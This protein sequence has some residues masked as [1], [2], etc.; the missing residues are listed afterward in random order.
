MGLAVSNQTE[1]QEGYSLNLIMSPPRREPGFCSHQTRAP[2]K[3]QASRLAKLEAMVEIIT[4]MVVAPA[5]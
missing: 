1:H 5:S 4:A 2:T 3:S